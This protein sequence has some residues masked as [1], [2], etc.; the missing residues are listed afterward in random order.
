MLRGDSNTPLKEKLLN[1]QM[2]GAA[3][4]QQCRMWIQCS[5]FPQV[6]PINLKLITSRSFLLCL[7]GLMSVHRRNLFLQLFFGIFLKYE[8]SVVETTSSV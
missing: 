5:P 4:Y 2:K 7:D 8:T 1:L 6:P 3:V